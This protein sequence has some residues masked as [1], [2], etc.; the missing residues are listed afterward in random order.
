MKPAKHTKKGPG[1]LYWGTV[2]LFLLMTLGPLAWALIVSVTPEFE[3]FKNT[4]A[5]LPESPTLDNYIRLF[6]TNRQSK[7]FWGA[8]LN[9]MRAAALTLAV[10]L[11]CAVCCAYPLSRLRFPGRR[12][13][14][15]LLLVTM[16]IPVFSTIIPL[17]K[18]FSEHQL[19]DNMFWLALVYV[20]AFLP[21]TTW[22]IANYFETI[23]REL[24][25]AAYI[26]GCSKLSTFFR[27]ILPISY[28]ILFSALLMIVLMS[29]NQF[30]IPLILASSRATKPVAIVTS[31]FVVKDSIQYGLT[32]AAGLTAILPPALLALFFHRFLIRGMTN[33]ATKG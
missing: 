30:Q 10:G 11:P 22:L 14:R 1:P 16:A 7:V 4:P 9:S 6:T 3:M 32:T 18:I 15:S 8:V 20:T 19:L 33:G 13:I 29:W 21:L 12:L 31:E 26:D 24:E 28:P 17:Y 23:P 25:E 27:V 2:A 5:F